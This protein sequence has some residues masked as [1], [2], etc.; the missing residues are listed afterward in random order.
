VPSALPRHSPPIEHAQSGGDVK[1]G[2]TPSVDD[3]SAETD[4]EKERLALLRQIE[5][6]KRAMADLPPLPPTPAPPT[7]GKTDSP[8]L[9]PT[10]NPTVTPTTSPTF[11]PTPSP[12]LLPTSSP[13]SYPTAPTRFPTPRATMSVHR[14]TVDELGRPLGIEK[15]DTVMQAIKTGDFSGVADLRRTG[16]TE[17]QEKMLQAAMRTKNEKEQKAQKVA[18][19]AE[20]KKKQQLR[21]KEAAEKKKA[22]LAAA[23]KQKAA[24]EKMIVQEDQAKEKRYTSLLRSLEDKLSG[25]SKNSSTTASKGIKSSV[26]AAET[27]LDNEIAGKS[28]PALATLE[29]QLATLQSEQGP[30]A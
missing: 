21:E 5:E 18:K 15:F 27:N 30:Q 29:G 1:T 12:T 20:E 2:S 28:N 13:T 11:Q 23:A 19:V 24:R 6:V 25:L 16:L 10:L 14:Q 8:T 17:L 4:E 22:L 9:M 3:D 7:P 26:G